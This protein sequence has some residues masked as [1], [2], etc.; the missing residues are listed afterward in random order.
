[1]QQ[2]VGMAM[3]D[4]ARA[5][6]SRTLSCTSLSRHGEKKNETKATQEKINKCCK[7]TNF[8]VKRQIKRVHQNDKILGPSCPHITVEAW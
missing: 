5:A 4:R 2:A 1:M 3:T 7:K 6:I 8:V